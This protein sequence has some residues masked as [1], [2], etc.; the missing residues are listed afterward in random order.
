M[1]R[2]GWRRAAASRLLLAAVLLGCAAAHAGDDYRHVLQPGETLIGISGQLLERPA[3]W[4]TLQRLNRIADPYHMLPG[5]VISIPVALLRREPVDARIAASKGDVRRDGQ[6]VAAGDVVRQGDPLS[7]GE[8]SFATV[9][10]VDGSRLVLQPSTRL[11]VER[12]VRVRGTTQTETRLHLDQG[13]VESSVSK[14][15]SGQPHFRID[16]PGATVGVRGTE[17]RVAEGDGPTRAE[18]SEG[19]VAV[20]GSKRR[21]AT[22]VAAGYGLVVESGHS[23]VPVAL[24][25]P[26]DLSGLPPLQERTIVRVSLPA[27]PEARAY[28]I[29]IAADRQMRDIRADALTDKPEAKFA[30]LPDGDYT[31]RARA[32]D[33]NGLEG[34]D[35]DFPFRLK[36]HP[37]PPFVI[38][39]TANAKLRAETAAFSWSSASEAARYRLQLAADAGFAAPLADIDAIDGTAIVPAKKLAPGEYWW[40]IRSLRADGDAGPWGDT[41]HFILKPLPANP[42]PPMIDDQELHFAWSAEPGQTFL[43]QFARDDGFTDLQSEQTLDHPTATVPRPA[44]GS[45]FMRVRATDPDGFVG[46]F[47]ST[48]RIA[49]PAKPPWWLLIMLLPVL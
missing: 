43:F 9:E 28:R 1:S 18:V 17:F 16:T 46:P 44:G 31:L 30:G 12:M 24:L 26:P 23:L 5:S 7:T 32:I 4:P 41:H 6:P 40:R 22:D 29:Q 13:R 27:I 21:V 14:S 48:Q 10:L 47:T 35:A 42:D 33:A 19:T 2:R 37:E 20:A 8:Q 34:R 45:Y 25:P 39:P 3:N 38:A 15:P 36:A 11:R 49:V